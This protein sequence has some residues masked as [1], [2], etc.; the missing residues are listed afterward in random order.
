MTGN[1]AMDPRTFVPRGS[2]LADPE[3][4]ERLKAVLGPPPPRGSASTGAI[5]IITDATGP[6]PE[7]PPAMQLVVGRETVAV[8]G[9]VADALRLLVGALADGRPVTVAPQAHMV[10]PHEAA[11]F[12]HLSRQVL[13]Q[14]MESGQLPFQTIG[15]HRRL[16]LQDVLAFHRRANGDR[17]GTDTG[18]ED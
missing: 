3:A 9:V 12:L 1:P 13:D 6:L 11:D 10:T 14:L 4:L 2:T 5:P 16:L 7:L 17:A 15:R 8:P 18:A